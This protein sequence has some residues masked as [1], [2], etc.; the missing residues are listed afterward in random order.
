MKREVARLHN[1]LRDLVPQLTD[2]SNR[3][4]V[5]MFLRQRRT[6]KELRDMVIAAKR[7]IKESQV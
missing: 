7:V 4:A 6:E 1:E 5:R 3:W 2:A